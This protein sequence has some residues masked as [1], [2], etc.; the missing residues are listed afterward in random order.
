LKKYSKTYLH[1]VSVDEVSVDEVSV[2]EVSVDEVNIKVITYISI[3]INPYHYPCHYLFEI[4]NYTT[5][6]RQFF[7]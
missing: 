3:A 6:S 4:H 5:F 2:D 1:E 7:L